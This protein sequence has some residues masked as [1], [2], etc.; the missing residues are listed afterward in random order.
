MMQ[1]RNIF[2]KVIVVKQSSLSPCCL[3][4]VVVF[5][6]IACQ[7]TLAAAPLL[8]VPKDFTIEPVAGPPRI[9]FPMFAALDDR[10]NLFVTESSGGDLYDELKKQ[11]RRC[12][13]T[14][15]AN[16]DDRGQFKTA[17]IFA[18]GLV[19][20]M[21]LVWRA[22]KLFV[23]DP[24]DLICL[25]DSDGDGRA[26]K[27]TV[28]LTGFG[29]TD[30]GS[31]H[32]LV[33]GPDGW[34]Y[35]T[36]GHPDGYRLQRADGSILSGSSGALLRCRADGSDIEV[37]S[38]GFENLVE[39]AFL[40]G[41]EIIGTDNWFSL[42]SAGIRDALVHLLEGA[43][44]PLDINDEGTAQFR[45]D[46]TLPPLSF[47][48]AVALS[49]LARYHGAAF[50]TEYSNA[51]F[52]AQHN[53]RKVIYHRLERLGSTFRSVDRDFV[54]TENPD[55]HPSDVLEDVDG[56]LLVVDTGS[57]YV[58]HCPTGR[59]RK[60]VAQGG[61]CRIR[62]A[63][64]GFVTDPCGLTLSWHVSIPELVQRLTQQSPGIRSRAATALIQRGAE[65]VGP[66]VEFLH[67]NPSADP[68]EE[69][70][71]ILAQIGNNA[72]TAALR[73]QLS[74]QDAD[75]VRLA[76]RAL[77]RVADKDARAALEGLL[78][79]PAPH[80]RLAAAEA[81]ARCGNTSS[82][83]PLVEALMGQC[84]QFLEHALA[85]ALYR[86]AARE[87]LGQLLNGPSPVIQ[88][89]ALLLLD[90]P[91][92]NSLKAEDLFPRLTA[93]N[94]QLRSAAVFIVR[95]HPEWAA[96]IAEPI[97]QLISQTNLSSLDSQTLQQLLLAFTSLPEIS[98]LVGRTV[99]SSSA[100]SSD[101]LRI[102]LLQVMRQAKLQAVP[103]DWPVALRTPLQRGSSAVQAEALRTK[104]ALHLRELD[105]LAAGIADDPARSD[106]LR[107][108]ALQTII[109]KDSAL[110]DS[111]FQ[112]ILKQLR[113]T[114]AAR[115]QGIELLSLVRLDDVQFQKLLEGL[116][117]DPLIAPNTVLTLAHRSQTKN[118][119]P[120]LD[121]IT[122]TV[123][124][125]WSISRDQLD[126]LA[127]VASPEERSKV[128][129][130]R[131][132]VEKSQA[133]PFAQ[134]QRMERLLTGGDAEGGREL[135]FG[136]AACSACHRIG[137]AGGLVGPDLT[138]IGAVR[139]GRDLL[140]SV[141]FPSATLAQGYESYR[142]LLH[143]G[144]EVT[145]VR[146]RQADGTFLL[147]DA[148]GVEHKLQENELESIQPL[149]LSLMPEGLLSAS[150]E[151]EI[152]DLFAYLQSRK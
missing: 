76:A 34:L 86:V 84:D 11:T 14:R 39:V 106:N 141:L 43:L 10:G 152:R 131:G 97:Q 90:Q 80:I 89:T 59:I 122:R 83:P 87:Q 75:R 135:F 82:V 64:R 150:S 31:L 62:G 53:A 57:W 151:A 74:S 13:I 96:G 128:E 147:R 21:G 18:D 3:L 17:G 93:S 148:S 4:L 52:S 108:Q 95:R 22:G 55:F 94:E 91:P 38:R 143:D 32:G 142:V 16:R 127:A 65:A 29:H 92:H 7:A 132:L 30:N 67:N 73:N 99:A 27:R 42:P 47:Y 66:L 81:L 100:E 121:Y 107:L 145:G 130:L 85:Y 101:R 9:Q 48:P 6:I 40:P 79:N 102:L 149:K 24:P 54:W 41:G 71:W 12:R 109:R 104:A 113:Q 133:D 125:G 134:L 2:L 49:G 103:A 139:S 37:I 77:G 116:A 112:L 78:S 140:E 117:G 115:L 61:L 60:S 44:Y 51:L 120:L 15:L 35:M 72:A 56:S 123:Q 105:D 114:P 126:W 1:S 144:E 20:P 25:E 58:H 146:V 98:R 69:T 136:K 137:N 46:K 28:I 5:A 111:A 23:A 119:H 33:F 138:T 68:F 36:T 50:P 63:Q 26:D 45:N 8:I 110:N 124:Q 70:I 19:F 129:Q 88:K 118:I